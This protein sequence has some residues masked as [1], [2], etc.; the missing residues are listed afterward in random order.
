VES[1]DSW[2]EDEADG[3]I[4]AILGSYAIQH[5]SIDPLPNGRGA[6]QWYKEGVDQ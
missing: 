1:V 5:T 3:E 4:D 2:P 6:D